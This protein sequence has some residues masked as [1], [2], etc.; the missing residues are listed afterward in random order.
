MAFTLQEVVPWGR[1]LSEYERMFALTPRD[2]KK[3]LLGCGDGPASFNA[4]A[5]GRG[6]RVVSCDPLYA[7]AADAI[8]ARI[9]ET[10]PLIIRQT[11]AHAGAY[12]WGQ[13]IDSIEALGMLRMSA[14][15]LFLQDYETGKAAGRYR[16]M[17][18]P[19]LE[20]ADGEFDLALCSHLL[21]LYSDH[22]GE[23]FHRAAV[24]E[25]MRVA[26]ELRIF[27]LLTLDGRPSPHVEAVMTQCAEAGFEARIEEVPYE[28]QKGANRMMRV[29]R[30]R[31]A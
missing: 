21:F 16:E 27:P 23:E 3:K 12:I 10:F 13:G 18:L 1:S 28:F 26:Q 5:A 4:E 22:L 8:R 11:R 2:F 24:A 6:C 30:N 29:S 19:S 9:A 25:M 31:D 14:M 7:L 15:T 17:A 20:F